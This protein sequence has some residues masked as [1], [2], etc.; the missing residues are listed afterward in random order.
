VTDPTPEETPEA[1][2]RGLGELAHIAGARV[3]ALEHLDKK[4]REAIAVVEAAQAGLATRSE[5]EDKVNAL[6]KRVAERTSSA[7]ASTQDASRR[8][9]LGM[10]LGLAILAAAV[11]GNR[12]ALDATRRSVPAVNRHIDDAAICASTHPG[13]EAASRACIAGHAR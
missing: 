9:M 6:E 3:A 13:D 1:V 8:R 4:V 12:L 11:I 10:L 7:L 2:A 5:L